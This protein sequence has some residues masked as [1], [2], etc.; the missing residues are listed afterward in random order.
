[1]A[2]KL[3]RSEAA[4]RG[5]LALVKIHGLTH[6]SKIASLG[7]I[8]LHKKYELR[9]VGSCDFV[10]VNRETGEVNPKTIN[11]RN[12]KKESECQ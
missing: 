9:P 7:G 6:M 3:T 4:R 10:L 11:G 5:G 12:W 2:E 8:A 1:M